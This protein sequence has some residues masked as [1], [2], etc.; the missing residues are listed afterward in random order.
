MPPPLKNISVGY[1]SR[2]NIARKQNIVIS[3]NLLYSYCNIFS[4]STIRKNF[5][6][7]IPRLLEPMSFETDPEEHVAP[8]IAFSRVPDEIL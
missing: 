6:N 3:L 2:S 8:L 4:Y 5:R 1:D 7:K